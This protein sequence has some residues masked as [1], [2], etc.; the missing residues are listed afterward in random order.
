[1]FF[2]TSP[3]CNDALPIIDICTFTINYRYSHAKF[4]E[5]CKI[6]EEDMKITLAPRKSKAGILCK[7]LPKYGITLEPPTQRLKGW[8]RIY[9]TPTSESL[10]SLQKWIFEL[11]VGD[12]EQVKDRFH[13]SRIE[14]AYEFSLKSNNYISHEGVAKRIFYRLWPVNFQNSYT[15][16]FTKDI[17]NNWIKYFDSFDTAIAHYGKCADGDIN[18]DFTGYIQS[19]KRDI[20]G[21]SS[22]SL[23]VNGRASKHTTV[24]VKGIDGIWRVRIELELSKTTCKNLIKLDYS[25]FDN[26]LI[27]LP[28]SKFYEFR[29]ADFPTFVRRLSHMPKLQEILQS[30]I[31]R[32]RSEEVEFMPVADKI[33]M[34]KAMKKETDDRKLQIMEQFTRKISFTEAINQK[35][36]SGAEP[37][38]RTAKGE[39]PGQCKFQESMKVLIHIGRQEHKLRPLTQDTT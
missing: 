18:G 39:K 5:L 10:L 16:Y 29:E 23:D 26:L 36:P 32:K 20:N 11:F 8:S 28:F 22:H 38:R 21:H 17:A 2:T 7:Y 19:C 33:R 3:A 1:M 14:L 9:F 15:T 25:H 27:S 12:F 13:L 6:I 31:W 35:L 34:M 24:Y 4:M 37:S 30:H